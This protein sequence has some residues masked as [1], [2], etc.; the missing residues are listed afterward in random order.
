MKTQS[1]MS[2][3][4]FQKLLRLV[5]SDL[6]VRR[7][8]LENRHDEISQEMNS[9]ERDAALE[10]LDAQINQVKTDYEHYQAFCDPHFD[11]QPSKYFEGPS[12][13]LPKQR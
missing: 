7:T 3:P 12:M 4:D 10:K 11:F 9:L 1:S 8:V 6:S 2:A 5:L 13:G